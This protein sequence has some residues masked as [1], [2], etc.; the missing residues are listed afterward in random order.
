MRSPDTNESCTE[1]SLTG[2][3]SELHRVFITAG[4]GTVGWG[5]VIIFLHR[6]IEE[7]E[8]VPNKGQEIA[9]LEY[10]AEDAR[11]FMSLCGV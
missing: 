10:S 3:Q 7:A 8:E 5:G 1:K 2:S 4:V 9:V 6:I 11:I